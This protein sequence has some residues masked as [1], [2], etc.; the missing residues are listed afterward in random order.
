MSRTKP[1]LARVRLSPYS[2]AAY[3]ARRRGL[4]FALTQREYDALIRLDCFYCGLSAGGI[5]RILNELGYVVGNCAPCCTS[6]N[7][8]KGA[9]TVKEWL[10]QLKGISERLPKVL[11]YF[12]HLLFMQKNLEEYKEV[13]AKVLE[14]GG[15]VPDVP[16]FPYSIQRFKRYSE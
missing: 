9:L 4:A 14:E 5:D 16:T 6:C 15:L 3:A 13:C 2:K 7:V 1:R 12:E 10:A 11:S 8:M